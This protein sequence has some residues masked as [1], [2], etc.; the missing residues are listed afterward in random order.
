MALDVRKG[1]GKQKKR[2]IDVQVVEDL[3]SITNILCRNIAPSASVILEDATGPSKKFKMTGNTICFFYN[4]SMANAKNGITQEEIDIASGR[5]ALSESNAAEFLERLEKKS[6]N[7]QK[8][9]LCRRSAQR[10]HRIKNNL[11][12]CLQAGLLHVISHLR[13]WN[14]QSFVVCQSTF[15]VERLLKFLVDTSL[16]ADTIRILMLAKYWLHN[17]RPSRS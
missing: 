15:S 12:G 17:L 4:D 14:G 8:A 9:L 16:G 3:D 5:I 2:R 11:S 13:K 6:E 10:D 1:S 7:I